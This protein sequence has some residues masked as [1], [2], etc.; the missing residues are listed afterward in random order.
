MLQSCRPLI[1]RYRVRILF[2]QSTKMIK[3]FRSFPESHKVKVPSNVSKKILKSVTTFGSR[4][5]FRNPSFK[6]FLPHSI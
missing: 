6:C 5:K 4:N 3:I 1:C 2:G